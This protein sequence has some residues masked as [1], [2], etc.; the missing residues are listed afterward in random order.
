MYLNNMSRL[1]DVC[2][3][4]LWIVWTCTS[5]SAGCEWNSLITLLYNLK[6]YYKTVTYTLHMLYGD[7]VGS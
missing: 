4:L 1:D 6:R 5:H 3:H 7:G 2:E